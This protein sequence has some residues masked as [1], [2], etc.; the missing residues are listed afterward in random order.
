[1]TAN[2]AE[3]INAIR[4]HAGALVTMSEELRIGGPTLGRSIRSWEE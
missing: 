3:L 1:M 2:R 4:E